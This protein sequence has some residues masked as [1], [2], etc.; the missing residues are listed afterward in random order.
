[1]MIG[2]TEVFFLSGVTSLRYLSKTSL[3]LLGWYF[4]LDRSDNSAFVSIRLAHDFALA[5][6]VKVFDV[7]CP[8][9]RICA[10]YLSCLFLMEAIGRCLSKPRRKT[11]V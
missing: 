7:L 6:L 1:M 11:S 8:L 4:F 9:M 5:R 10:W 2:S 3:K